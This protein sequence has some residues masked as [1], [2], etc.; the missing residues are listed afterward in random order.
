MSLVIINI[1][2][3]RYLG[4]QW[5]VIISWLVIKMSMPEDISGMNL[6]SSFL[7]SEPL[8]REFLIISIHAVSGRCIES[9]MNE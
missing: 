4:L 7:C 3:F 2:L 1:E 6:F 5:D 8:R 9:S